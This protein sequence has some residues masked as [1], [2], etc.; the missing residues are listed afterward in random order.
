MKLIFV[1]SDFSGLGKGTFAASLGRVFKSRSIDTRVM[2]CDLYY[3]YD[4][5]T[6]N[7]G[8]HGEV[9]VLA[10]GTET[11]QDLGIYE[12]FLGQECNTLDYLT[13]G[14]VFHQVYLNERAGKYLGKTVSVEHVIDEIKDRIRNFASQC[15]VGIVELGAT[16]GDIK[17]IYFLEA[18]RQLISELGSSNCMFVL[19]SHFPFLMNVGEIKTMGC[20]RSVHELRS[21]GLKAD[22][23]I[24]RTTDIDSIPDYQL[25]KI[26]LF[27]EV[28]KEATFCVP[29]LD[30]EYELPR[31]LRSVKIDLYIMNT[32]KIKS[33]VDKLDDWY[34]RFAEPKEI[35]IAMVGKYSH[36]DAYVSIMQQLKMNGVHSVTFMES[37]AGLE[38]FDAVIIPGGW[39]KRG[40]EEMVETARICRESQ[41]P[42]LGICLGLQILLIEYARNVLGMKNAN[43][44]EFD[45]NTPYPVVKLQEEQKKSKNLG[46]TA[47]LGNWTTVFKPDTIVSRIYGSNRIV[48]RHRHRYEI[49][50]DFK[51]KDFIVSGRDEKT[52]LIETMELKTHRF[53]L[54]V[55]Y[56]PEFGPE[57]NPIFTALIQAAKDR[58]K[59]LHAVP[60][61]K[62]KQVKKSDAGHPEIDYSDIK[63]LTTIAQ[64]DKASLLA[65][66]IDDAQYAMA[67]AIVQSVQDKNLQIS[68]VL[69]EIEVIQ[70]QMREINMH[71]V[72]MEGKPLTK[73]EKDKLK[74]LQ[75]KIDENRDLIR[76]I[77]DQYQGNIISNLENINRSR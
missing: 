49:S 58:K 14:R 73:A 71:P 35:K 3:N 51:T 62:G 11:D 23:I 36:P 77:R 65:K 55:Q 38:N 40:I 25:N 45:P 67:V 21:K 1:A 72:H 47:R 16:I 4:A 2:K 15:D 18:C 70:Q 26:R 5:G 34:H 75:A 50:P 37:P 27:C 39:G 53:H 60:K 9:Y 63:M 61:T 8:E 56:H 31:Y 64:M 20:Q 24:A 32:M 42:V 57:K 19:L 28:P 6:I 44:T 43:S 41:I 12:R 30:N 54:G 76:D 74:Q 29:D 52:N 66:G 68:G 46:G 48:Q 69:D 13:S 10:D 22:I 33:T 17:G 59:S 7:P